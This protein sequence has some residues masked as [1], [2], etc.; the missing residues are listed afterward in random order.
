MLYY[1]LIATLPFPFKTA[2]HKGE[3]VK[4][5]GFLSKMNKKMNIHG[6]VNWTRKSNVK[7]KVQKKPDISDLERALYA[8]QMA[9][10]VKTQGTY[11]SGGKND[12]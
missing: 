9:H 2:R 6:S 5:S 10:S 11:K 1:S 7:G 8:R 12:F 3:V 4:L